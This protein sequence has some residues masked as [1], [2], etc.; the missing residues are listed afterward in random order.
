MA[1]RLVAKMVTFRCMPRKASEYSRYYPQQPSEYVAVLTYSTGEL[2]SNVQLRFKQDRD[3]A[4]GLLIDNYN[5][6]IESYASTGS[7]GV[8][9]Y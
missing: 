5:F 9:L 4:N 6:N 8:G 3:S 2:I 7:W 1:D